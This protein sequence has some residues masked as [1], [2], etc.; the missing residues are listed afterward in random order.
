MDSSAVLPKGCIGWQGGQVVA[1]P[2]DPDGT[3]ATLW[4]GDG[5]EVRVDGKVI[6]EP[7]PIYGMEQIDVRIIKR[8]LFSDMA[9]VWVDTGGTVAFL[10]VN[11]MGRLEVADHPPSAEWKPRL[12][13]RLGTS[14][15][16]AQV[17]AELRRI[18]VVTGMYADA[19]QAALQEADGGPI[20]ITRAVE[21]LQ[22]VP[23]RVEWLP[24][25]LGA[26]QSHLES[27]ASSLVI[28]VSPGQAFARIIP[29]VPGQPGTSVT[30]APLD[31]QP[32]PAFSVVLAPLAVEKDTD[33]LLVAKQP[34]RPVV[35]EHKGTW[36]VALIQCEL[37]DRDVTDSIR[38]ANDLIVYGSVVDGATIEVGGNLFV[39]GNMVR[40]TVRAGG[41]ITVRGNV[42]WCNLQAGQPSQAV[43]DFVGHWTALADGIERVL[44]ICRQLQ[45]LPA[46]Q[47]A[48][49]QYHGW[50]S[51]L[52]MLVKRHAARLPDLARQLAAQDLPPLIRK[53][54]LVLATEAVLSQVHRLEFLIALH[55]EITRFQLL[56]RAVS[57][58][59]GDICTDFADHSR[60]SAS[61][62][63]LLTGR[64]AFMCKLQAGGRIAARKAIIG[65]QT[66]GM[67]LAAAELGNS[68]SVKT[69][70]GVRPG[71]LNCPVIHPG[72]EIINSPAAL[73]DI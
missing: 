57:A 21:A 20:P 60:L 31:P 45:S 15:T 17:E 5:I 46:F 11:P 2:P 64:G 28:R 55:E 23:G 63:I 41:S 22:P 40:A 52:P 27:P 24:E 30:G 6:T 35:L 56:I 36:A 69:L 13:R 48:D 19:V 65:G 1:Y 71:A 4:P 54:L 8:L 39:Q 49:L 32:T 18:G 50:G 68:A 67:Q 26:V 62:D 7:T 51:I 44:A 47:T 72:C 33:N 12:V 53:G 3:P 66:A 10:Q 59:P 58:L 43:Q 73:A 25:I 38:T 61:R 42:L 16:P 34:G 29:P 14:L 9:R 37:L 70:V